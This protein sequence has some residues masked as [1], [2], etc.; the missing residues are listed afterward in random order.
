MKKVPSAAPSIPAS[1]DRLIR[2]KELRSMLG[3]ASIS[4]IYRW[5]A[6]GILPEP[7]R[8]TPRFIGWRASD[9]VDFLNSRKN[10]EGNN[11]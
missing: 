9:I 4:T 6:K 1:P 7:Q 2:V 5:I 8:L 3:G 11:D 10:G